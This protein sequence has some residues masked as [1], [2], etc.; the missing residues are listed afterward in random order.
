MTDITELL[1]PLNLIYYEY[2]A[3]SKTIILDRQHT[4]DAAME[5]VSITHLFQ[6]HNIQYIVDNKKNLHIVRSPSWIKK[7]QY[8]LASSIKLLINRQY[9]IYVLNDKE[10]DCAKNLPVIDINPIS[11]E[12]DFDLYDGLIFT[13]KNA[14]FSIES[15]TKKW[16]KIPIYALAPQTAKAVKKHKAQL[17][18]VG[19]SHY[20]NTF[21]EEL[22]K[23]L[24][25]KK[26][27]YLRAKN[28]ASDL[29]EIL[30]KKGVFCDEKIVYETTCRQFD[31]KIVLPKH[32]TVVFSSPSTIDCFFK[33][34]D[35]DSTY[36][37]IAI[38]HTT[39]QCFPK[40][41]TPFIAETTS[42]DACIRKAMSLR[43]EL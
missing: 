10:V 42:I 40:E 21:A 1:N 28:V 31:Q 32:S 6:R 7:L 8:A 38:G 14:L 20:G 26:V 25:G 13:S 24:Q 15:F 16:K 39:A 36:T 18:F 11:S 30:N 35:W 5:L 3:P 12:I 17:R 9:D 37:A 34:A 41:I 23:P 4:T 19:K 2:D 22:L 29:C 43:Q 33:N 27:L